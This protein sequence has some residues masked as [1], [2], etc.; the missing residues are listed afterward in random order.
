[1]SCKL[2][3][4]TY[5]LEAAKRTVPMYKCI[6]CNSRGKIRATTTHARWVGLGSCGQKY[7]L[8]DIHAWRKQ[9]LWWT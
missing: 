4:L 8:K 6:Q 5:L 9:Q 2:D 1:V 3:S 7:G